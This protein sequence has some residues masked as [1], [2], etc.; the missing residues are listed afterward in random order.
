MT[1]QRPKIVGEHVRAPKLSH[2]VAER[3]RTQIADGELSAGDSLP[4][5]A[6]LLQQFGVSRPTLREA[7]R[8]LE[9][10]TLIQLGRG[11]RSGAMVL[12][13]SIEAVARYSGTFLAS[14]GTTIA[15]IHQVRMLLEP[16]LAS[17]IAQRC[18]REDIKALRACVKMQQDALRADDHLGV[19]SAVVQFHDAMVR[20]S[21]NG[22]L[23]LLSGML[24]D[25]SL[26]VYP[27]MLAAG[28]AGERQA[29]KRRTEQSATAHAEFMELVASGNHTDAE[30]FW[31]NY[32]QDTAA[33]LTRTGL[34]KLRVQVSADYANPKNG[35]RK[36]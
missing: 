25:I 7:L 30:K 32:M 10:E 9:S 26:K 1:L 14:R 24:H 22:A 12:G 17:M 8:V 35:R 11:A 15:E 16:S 2:L 6:E 4:S 29:V 28:S 23:S 27:Q 19:I 21:D 20:C 31:R 18:R 13:P 36:A 3:L 5:E 33:F 34:G